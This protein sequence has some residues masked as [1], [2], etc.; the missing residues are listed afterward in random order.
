[1]EDNF[2]YISCVVERSHLLWHSM[3]L[4][5]ILRERMLWWMFWK[6]LMF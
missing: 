2:Y 5:F 6:K 1:M 4:N 3:T